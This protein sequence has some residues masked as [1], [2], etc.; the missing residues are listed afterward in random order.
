MS[1]VGKRRGLICF[2]L[3]H[4]Y[5][6]LTCHLRLHDWR[7]RTRQI[8][9]PEIFLSPGKKQTGMVPKTVAILAEPRKSNQLTALRNL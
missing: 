1:G 8:F 6:L 3:A 7:R 4:R 2:L 5:V 9:R